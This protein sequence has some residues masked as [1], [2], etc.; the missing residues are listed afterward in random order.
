MGMA[1]KTGNKKGE[2][3]YE[4]V[5]ANGQLTYSHIITAINGTSH[6]CRSQIQ[7]DLFCVR[8]AQTLLLRDMIPSA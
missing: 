8:G 4:A 3:L 2:I 5:G 1:L 6:V 7:P